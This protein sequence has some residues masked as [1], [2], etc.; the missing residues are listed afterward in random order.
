VIVNLGPVQRPVHLPARPAAGWQSLLPQAD[1]G[2][3]MIAARAVGFYV[4]I[5]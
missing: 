4:E 2:E 1:A 3:G 5:M